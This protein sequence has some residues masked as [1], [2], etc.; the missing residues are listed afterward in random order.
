MAFALIQNPDGAMFQAQAVLAMVRDIIG[1]G[2]EDSYDIEYGEYRS[3]PKVSMWENG[4][5]RGYIIHMKGAPRQTQINVGFWEGRSG[6][7]IEVRTFEKYTY[8]NGP[9]RDDALG[10]D[11]ELIGDEKIFDYGK[12]EEAARHIADVLAEFWKRK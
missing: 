11:G 1:D 8:L 9:T 7:H 12:I 4:R 3:E 5:E 6:D 10:P 2:I